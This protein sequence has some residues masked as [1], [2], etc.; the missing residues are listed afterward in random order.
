MPGVAIIQLAGG[1][2]PIFVGIGIVF[3]VVPFWNTSI[4]L[5]IR[6]GVVQ[7]KQPNPKQNKKRSK[8]DW[9]GVCDGTLGHACPK[10]LMSSLVFDTTSREAGGAV[11]RII[12][13]D[14]VRVE[15]QVV[16]ECRSEGWGHPGVA[17]RA[18]SPE[19]AI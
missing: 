14:V 8:T 16:P 10:Y 19:L 18:N 2:L 6:I 12:E 17:V 7:P 1:K 4:D 11:A 9:W 5:V 13:I 3:T 15:V